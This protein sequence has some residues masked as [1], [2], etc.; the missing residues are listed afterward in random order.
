L[1]T[2]PGFE[3]VGSGFSETSQAFLLGFAFLFCRKI[4]VHPI[5]FEPPTNS[6]NSQESVLQNNPEN[7]EQLAR[8]R[9]VLMD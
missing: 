1:F 5:F 3:K 7:E 2:A 6:K 9:L 4:L 8:S